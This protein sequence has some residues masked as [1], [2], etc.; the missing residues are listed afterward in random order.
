LA[1]GHFKNL[2]KAGTLRLYVDIDAD[3]KKDF[4]A[5]TTILIKRPP[6]PEVLDGLCLTLPVK[7]V[8]TGTMGEEI[9]LQYQFTNTLDHPVKNVTVT[10]VSAGFGI[11]PGT[12]INRYQI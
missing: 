3:E 9:D 4:T 6:P 10:A 1:S 5:S 11:E 2:L 7:P 8:G 12:I